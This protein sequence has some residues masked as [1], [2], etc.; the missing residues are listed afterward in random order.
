MDRRRFVAAS[1]TSVG[2]IAAALPGATRT[3]AAGGGIV[4]SYFG[5]V[6]A[7]NPPLGQFNDL[8]SFHDAGVVTESRRYLIKGTP[9]GDLLETSGHGAWEKTGGDTYEAFF[10][11]FIQDF[12][13]G[14]PIGTDNVH[15]ALTLDKQSGTLSGTFESQIR[16]T[17][18]LVLL[19]V[20][21]TYSATPIT[22]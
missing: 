4:G 8:I 6:T 16:N 12:S 17:A 21:G 7:T 3:E 13:T 2:V 19:I 10:R 1:V 20:T 22:V 18:D 11:F 5:T 9:L 15:L 14:D